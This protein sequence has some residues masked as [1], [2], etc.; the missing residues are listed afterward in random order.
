VTYI[1]P[2]W[3]SSAADPAE[4]VESAR[5]LVVG[6]I[7]YWKG[8]TLLCEALRL[9][10]DEA[11]LIEWAGRDTDYQDAG[12]SMSAYLARHYPDVWGKK[13]IPLGPRSPEATA[14]LQAAA[15]FILVP[16]VWDV[17]NYTCIEGMGHGRVVLCSEGAGAAGLITSGEDGLTFAANAPAALADCLRQGLGMDAAARKR[18]G[19]RARRTIAET[20]SPPLVARQRLAAYENLRERGKAYTP[21][22]DWLTDAVRPHQPLPRSM[23]FLDHLPLR[24]LSGY[25]LSRGLKKFWN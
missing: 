17:L 23:A 18:M 2:A 10:G 22:H 9:M 21:P 8:P 20:L 14:A 12:A 11:P 16:S 19:E 1:P 7:Q 6:R 15:A 13:I 3:Q 4:I 5:G 24:E 25:A